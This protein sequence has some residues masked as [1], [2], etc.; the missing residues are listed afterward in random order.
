[1]VVEC[2]EDRALLTSTLY[3]DYGDRFPGGIL[4]TTVGALDNTTNGANPNIDGPVLSDA[5]NNLYANGTAV[6]ITSVNTL[7]GA[8]AAAFRATLTALAQRFYEPFDITVVELTADLQNV[9]GFN[10]RAAVDL[11]EISTT[12][13]LNEGVGENNDSYVI[14]GLFQIGAS[15]DNP[16]NFATNGYGG[17]ATGTDIAANNNNDGTAFVLLSGPGAGA[18]FNGD[19]IAHE[20]GHLFGLQHAY[21]QDTNNA[22]PALSN[23]T[24]T[25]A[26]YDML[27]QSE[28]MSYLGYT[29]QGGFNVFSRYPVMDGDGNTDANNLVAVGGTL[30]PYDQ[31]RNDPNIGPSN[32][33]YVTGTGAHDIITITK[34][35][36]NSANVSVQAFFD[37]SYSTAI[38]APGATGNTYSHSIALDRPLTIDAGGNNDRVILDGD[39]GVTITLRGMHG[40]DELIVMG[41]N[42]A[43]GTYI[44]GTNVTN[45]LD[46]NSD[47]RG[48]V[49]IGTTTINF[50]EFETASRVVVQDVASLTLRTPLSNDVLAVVSAPA[51]GQ[52][53]VTGTSGGVAIVPLTFFNVASLTLDTGTN[54]GGSPADEVTANTSFVASGLTNLTVSTG[55]GTDLLRTTLSNY[56]L[57]VAGG[58]FTFQGGAGFDRIDATADVSFNLSDSSL[59]IVG[60]S[61]IALTSVE[62]AD[63]TGGASSNTFTV[64]N[65]TGVA[66]LDAVGGGDSYIVNFT[67][68][69]SGSV[70][71]DDSG[72]SGT[73]TADVNGTAADNGLAVT[74]TGVSMSGET[75][76]YDG[77]ESLA[78]NGHAGDDTINVRSTTASTPVTVNGGDDDDTIHFGSVGNSLDAILGAVTVN[79]NAP[80]S[81][82][83]LH[84]NDHGDADSH[85]YVI[86]STTVARTGAAQ[87]T[88]GTIESLTLNGGQGGNTINVQS[89]AAGTAV[90]VNSGSGDDEIAVDANGAG[91][92]ADTVDLVVSSLTINGQGGTN[93]LLLEDFSDPNAVAPGDVV[94]VTPTQIGA[95]P[96]DSFFGTGGSL[97]YSG[98]D[99]VTLNLSNGYFP[100][101][102]YVVPSATTE[103]EL[104]GNDPD[105]PM[106]PDQLPGDA[107]YVDFTGVTDP[108]LVSDGDGNSVWTF[109]NR[110]DVAFDGFEKLNHVGIIVVAPD[111]GSEPLVR[112]FDAETGAEKF[113]FYAFDPSFNGGVR[114]AVGDTTCDGIPDIIVAAGPG[115]APEV[116]VFNGATGVPLSGAL[117]SFLAYDEGSRAGVWVAAGDINQDG[118]TDIITGPDNGGG[119]PLVK[120]FSGEDG[121]LHADFLAYDDKF[122]GGVRVAAGDINGDS[123]PDIVTAPGPGHAPEVRV[124][125]GTDLTGPAIESFLA[126]GNSYRRGL[127]LAVGDV[128]GDGRADI[129]A[130]GGDG[131][132]RLVRV[133][134]GTDVTGGP[135]ASFQPYQS[136]SGDSLRVALVDANEDGDLELVVAPGPGGQDD[137][138]VFDF[139]AALNPE[140]VDPF[141][142]ALFESTG[143]YFVAGG[144]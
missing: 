100:D 5:N 116:R 80:A 71:I 46:G 50:Q 63:L 141:F 16:A 108:L 64:S 59:A 125:D 133:F 76:T 82:D 114:V 12:L 78:V 4:N 132:Q 96:T 99:H 35:G 53:R 110:E 27:H 112:V 40:T 28:L 81:S 98:L 83:A 23:T 48:S 75:V 130:S 73:D 122:Q 22:P 68:A 134:D 66:N 135:V 42:A 56:A 18:N 26:Q 93:S 119:Q 30:T 39:L 124:F 123:V 61:S 25:G 118:F 115:S 121:S 29:S 43:S 13:G 129:V 142:D 79:G 87:I 36:A 60:D 65:W 7:M 55:P 131:G 57:P 9:N 19:Q 138:K 137:P 54:D 140:E 41:K 52:N 32:I 89:T 128:T 45:G 109:G 14:V 2:L 126:F 51:A 127:Y 74:S 31:H 111:Q 91:P 104:H 95:D 1:M 15:N 38:D 120:V 47:R 70:D 105:C 113:S 62:R 49:V 103:F 33:E 72:A 102:A 117:G 94:H 24:A 97:T 107:L 69:G 37:G 101:T 11:N 67:G 92:L 20:A 3:I 139:D 84:V 90:I 143:G 44:P 86:T 144:G 77:V 58:A 8:G 21:R 10:A 6:A 136:Q 17:L 85:D 34:T 106:N 88:Y